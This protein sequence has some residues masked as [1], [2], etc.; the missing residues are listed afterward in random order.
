MRGSTKSITFHVLL[1][2]TI[3]SLYSPMNSHASLFSGSSMSSGGS[4]TPS[5]SSKLPPGTKY[6]SI[7][8]TYVD[9]RKTNLSFGSNS[10]IQ[11]KSRSSQVKQG[12]VKFNISGIPAGAKITKA[13]ISL[14]VAKKSGSGNSV[15]VYEALGNWNRSTTW[16]QKPPIASSSEA[17][18]SVSKTGSYY[19]MSVTGLVQDW[20]N[21]TEENNGIYVVA[22]NGE[23][24][25]YSGESKKNKPVLTVEYTKGGPS[26][27]PAPT[28]VPSPAPTPAPT[29]APS[30]APTPAPTPARRP[31]QHRPRTR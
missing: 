22:R 29:P 11:I 6:Y 30:P 10:T 9:Q 23:M 7:Q 3:L 8:D 20:V 14:Y 24:Y 5:G 31:L 18:M 26:A 2:V 21:G 12:L 28:P 17:S 16:N 15:A 25:F 13:T 27:T 19:N 4:S 1:A